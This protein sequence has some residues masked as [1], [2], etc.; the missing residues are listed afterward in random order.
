MNIRVK[1]YGFVALVVVALGVWYLA[2]NYYPGEDVAKADFEV[3][4]S[5]GDADEEASVPVRLEATRQG[6]ISSFLTST[7]NLRPLRDVVLTTQ[8]TGVVKEVLVEEGDRVEKGRLLCLLDD[9][10][11][12]IRLKLTEQKLAQAK[13]QLEKARI[14]ERKAQI[15]IA[16]TQVE[17]VR[18]EDAYAE[19]A[20][21][22]RGGRNPS[23]P[24]PGT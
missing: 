6:P 10:E 13:L 1:V 18:K 4:G 21:K 12:L 14:K 16:N 24:G 5:N 9:T 20:G 17:L 19:R 15:Q 3:D 7:S 11:L 8:A 2:A 22:R 23:L